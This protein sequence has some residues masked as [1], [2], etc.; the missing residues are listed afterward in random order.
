MYI[1]WLKRF[2]DYGWEF[3]VIDKRLM[4]EERLYRTD[5]MGL[6]LYYFDQKEGG[7]RLIDCDFYL[8]EDSGFS[9]RSILS[10]RIKKRE[11]LCLRIEQLI[12]ERDKLFGY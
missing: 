9:V 8:K 2:G 3:L 11:D 4:N 12:R 6:N 10:K 1:S 5:E 7:F